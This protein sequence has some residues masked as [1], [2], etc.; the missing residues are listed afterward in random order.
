MKKTIL[1][2]IACSSLILAAS[3]SDNQ[4][5]DSKEVAKESNEQKVDSNKLPAQM[6]DDSKF[7]VAAAD[8]GM[9]EVQLGKLAA[10][11]AS[12]KTVKDLGKMMVSDHSA[13]NEELKALAA[14]KNITLPSGLSDKSQKIYDKLAAKT[15]S[16]FDKAYTE[17]MVDDH[18]EDISDFKKEVDKG[19][20][21]DVK[22]WAAGKVPVL[23]HHL[24]MSKTAKDA[25]HK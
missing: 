11:N 16:D 1:G 23:E 4:S 24:E 17:D 2:L 8:G 15:G 25:V 3:C 21:A 18:N 12:S 19:T 6:E 20:D 7:A 14:R 22:A 13:A 10:T 9:L 5:T